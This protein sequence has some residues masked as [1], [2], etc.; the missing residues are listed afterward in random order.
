MNT[1]PTLL[2]Q[3]LMERRADGC[4]K[5]EAFGE[6]TIESSWRPTDRAPVAAEGWLRAN[7]Y[8]RDRRLR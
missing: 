2:T 7:G 4:A 6:L 1:R 5:Q 8:A 3:V